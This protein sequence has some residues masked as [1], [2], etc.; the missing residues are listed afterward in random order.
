A[1]STSFLL[2]LAGPM[3]PTTYRTQTL[4]FGNEA[5]VAGLMPDLSKVTVRLAA[6][7]A[8]DLKRSHGGSH[9]FR[10]GTRQA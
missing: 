4:L 9:P 8:E 1:F 10:I 6:T 7:G 2:A 5:I 3:T